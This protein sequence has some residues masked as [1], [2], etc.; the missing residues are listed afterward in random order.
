MRREKVRREI[1]N[2][3]FSNDHNSGNPENSNAGL[4][5]QVTRH[6]VTKKRVIVLITEPRR[7][8]QES[9]GTRTYAQVLNGGAKEY[10][11]KIPVAEN[12]IKKRI[13]RNGCVS[14]MVNNLLDNA[15]MRELWIFFSIGRQIKDII[16]PR[17]RSKYNTRFGFLVVT[18]L[19]EAWGLISQFNGMELGN[20]ILVL[21]LAKD[22]QI[23]V[24]AGQFMPNAGKQ[25]TQAQT[26]MHAQQPPTSNIPTKTK[27]DEI[28]LVE[29][30]SFKTIQ[31]V[32]SNNR[33]G[34]L[35]RSLIVLTKEATREDIMQ[36]IILSRGFKFI[37][38]YPDLHNPS[39][40]T[41]K[42]L[43]Q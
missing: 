26:K 39:I 37:K 21:H 33:Q 14:V 29:Q 27:R 30:P 34:M 1:S 15:S 40:M 42:H 22:S 23:M 10:K 11:G 9:L 13:W 5:F 36:E 3:K 7:Q 19:E 2:F 6:P 4:W 38:H 16:L 8:S 12:P 32:I 17:K 43:S 24:D 35:D 25:K 31:G 20:V 28:D 41:K 18:K